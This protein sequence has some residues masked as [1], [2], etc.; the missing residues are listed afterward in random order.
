MLVEWTGASRDEATW[1][2]FDSLKEAF[3]HT[4]LEDKV[5]FEIEGI[6][7][8]KTADGVVSSDKSASYVAANDVSAHDV[9]KETGRKLDTWEHNGS[10]KRNPPKWTRDYV[11][12]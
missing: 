11:M 8:N 5:I 1:E 6:D 9:E 4:D 12:E 7:M 2:D 3:P 10:R